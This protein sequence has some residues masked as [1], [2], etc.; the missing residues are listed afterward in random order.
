MWQ[1]LQFALFSAN[2]SFFQQNKRTPI[3]S[4]VEM[5]KNNFELPWFLYKLQHDV[6]RHCFFP[7][8]WCNLNGLQ[9]FLRFEVSQKRPEA[10]A[11]WSHSSNASSSSSSIISASKSHGNLLELQ[12]FS[13]PTMFT[14]KL[15]R[16][17]LGLQAIPC[18][19]SKQAVRNNKWK[20][21][22]HGR[23]TALTKGSSMS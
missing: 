9:L 12:L 10:R 6:L 3:W 16:W 21:R 20:Q 2:S 17:V 1:V 5:A 4:L 18:M 15:G 19:E 14:W 23:P 22:F 11:C 7:F 8:F 13:K